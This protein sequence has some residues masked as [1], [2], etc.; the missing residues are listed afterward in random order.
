[1]ISSIITISLDI[2]AVIGCIAFIIGMIALIYI[3]C[4]AI[5]LDIK[6][7]EGYKDYFRNLYE[8]K[9]EE[10]ID[11]A[12]KDYEYAKETRIS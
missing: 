9:Y 1:M 8:S 6:G 3:I 10:D 12:K 2:A 5:Y 11:K 7:A 4:K